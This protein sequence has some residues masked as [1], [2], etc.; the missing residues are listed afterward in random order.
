M[1][2]F[3]SNSIFAVDK[4]LWAEKKAKGGI[5]M[6]LSVWTEKFLHKYLVRVDDPQQPINGLKNLMKPYLAGYDGDIYYYSIDQNLMLHPDQSLYEN[7]IGMNEQIL[8]I[9]PEDAQD[10][11]LLV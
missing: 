4:K 9:T 11:Q 3:V 6:I 7:M 5:S 10:Y 1:K 8:L 2:K